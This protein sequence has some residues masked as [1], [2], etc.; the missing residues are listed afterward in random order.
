MKTYLYLI[1]LAA[2]PVFADGC[3]TRGVTQQV[4]TYS[5]SNLSFEGDAKFQAT[6]LLRPVLMCGKIS[7][8][9]TSLPSNLEKRVGTPVNFKSTEFQ[10]YLA[11]NKIAEADVGGGLDRP[12]SKTEL[13]DP[14]QYF[15]IHDTSTPNYGSKPFPT[16]ID[17][18]TWPDNSLKHWAKGEKSK[19]HVFINR[20]GESITAMPFERG[21]R[22]VKFELTYAQRYPQASE[23]ALRG[24]FLHVELVQPRRSALTS[25]VG[26]MQAPAPGFTE[27]QYQRLALV[28]IAASIRAGQWLIPAYHAGLDLGITGGH[29]DP[30][31]FELDSWSR[32]IDSLVTEIN[33][34]R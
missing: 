12:L 30:Q 16:D 26:D 28:Y 27:A 31:H 7:A 29:D 10:G 17:K 5:P 20:L 34:A 11:A 25:G 6:C 19:A 22:A 15:V 9:P 32:H 3:P 21:W 23:T 13:G 8:T 1:A 18:P 2:S 14:A 24:R 33:A 4:C